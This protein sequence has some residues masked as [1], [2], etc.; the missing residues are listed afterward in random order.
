M[1]TLIA[2]LLACAIMADGIGKIA[3]S[4]V[5]H[6]DIMIGTT[7]GGIAFL[8]ALGTTFFSLKILWAIMV[9]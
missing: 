6:R 7:I 3:D 1:L 5:Q 4:F 9:G 8:F 2:G